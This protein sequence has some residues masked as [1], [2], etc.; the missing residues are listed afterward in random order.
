M[1]RNWLLSKTRAGY[2]PVDAGPLWL[3][4]QLDEHNSTGNSKLIYDKGAYVM[5][6][7]R[8]MMFDPKLKNPD[9]RFLAM[10]H[11][12]TSTYAGQNA[13]T[14][15][16][17]LIVEKHVGSPMDWFFNQWV[18]GRDIPTYDFSYRLSDADAGQTE[19]TMSI[20][21][22]GVPESF[23]MNLPVYA[24]VNGEMCYL[25]LIGVTGTKPT[26]VSMKLP[27]HPNKIVLDPG[28]SIL[29]E[30]HQ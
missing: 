4:P 12:F 30:V 28:H 23:Q 15:D 6:M 16:F 29:A 1:R 27:L 14:E 8:A 5:E 20:T 7:L 11:D 10:M 26:K 25:G 17:R 3:N 19:L 21:Q 18:Y 22:S 2:R 24:A 9:G 13:S